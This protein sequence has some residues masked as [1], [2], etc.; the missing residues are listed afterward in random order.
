MIKPLVLAGATAVLARNEPEFMLF[1]MSRLSIIV[2][3][4]GYKNPRL[5]RK[6]CDLSKALLTGDTDFRIKCH[7]F[8]KM[9]LKF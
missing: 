3:H 2:L 4:N 5:F 8:C 9:F 6:N 7:N 1:E